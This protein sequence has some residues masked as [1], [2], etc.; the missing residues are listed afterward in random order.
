MHALLLCEVAQLERQQQKMQILRIVQRMPERLF[1]PPTLR[2][3]RSMREPVGAVPS[4][5]DQDQVSKTHAYL[6]TLAELSTCV[7]QSLTIVLQCPLA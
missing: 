1:D 4:H 7:L 2:A 3:V 5:R 6:Q